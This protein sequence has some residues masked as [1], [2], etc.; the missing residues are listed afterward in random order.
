M[1]SKLLKYDFKSL[2]KSLIPIYLIG[3]F[4]AVFNFLFQKLASKIVILELPSVLILFLWV[5]IIIG[6]PLVTFFISISKYYNNIIKDEGYLTHT[7]PVK[8]NQLIMSKLISSVLVMILSVIVSLII[9]MVGYGIGDV[10]EFVTTRL[11]LIEVSIIILILNII[12]VLV[13]YI[14]QMIMVYTAISLGQIHNQN[15]II[16]SIVYGI[17]MYT[18]NQIISVIILIIP[19]L[20]DRNFLNYFNQDN[21]PEEAYLFIVGLSLIMSIVFSLVY[22]IINI[23][24]LEKKLNLE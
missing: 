8:K 19:V 7:L 2:L 9:L 11:S 5:V 24:T 10:I 15:K 1:L 20:F 14:L 12:M 21:L 18:L 13:S 6:I 22:Y 23:K 17:V 3:L 4:I 16:Y